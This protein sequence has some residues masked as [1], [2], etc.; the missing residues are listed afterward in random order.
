MKETDLLKRL[1]SITTNHELFELLNEQPPTD[2]IKT[3]P[4]IT[5]YRYLSIDKVEL[6]LKTIF[7]FNYKI[8]LVDHKELFNTVSVV[9]RVHY[10]EFDE[11]NRWLHFDGAA[12]E[13]PERGKASSDF[14]EFTP[15]AIAKAFPSAKSNAIRNACLS[16]GNLFGNNL[17]RNNTNE[18]Q[19][20]TSNAKMLN[21]LIELLEKKKAKIQYEDQL[22]Y[23]RIIDDKETANYQKAIK[24]LNTI[25]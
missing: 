20:K 22:H 24:E 17:N 23:Q 9:M 7:K 2:W 16:F 13:E 12:A 10:K 5:E 15:Y 8:E 25:K 14:G 4:E 19:P 3:H 11:P 18:N 1:D 6:L 21:Q